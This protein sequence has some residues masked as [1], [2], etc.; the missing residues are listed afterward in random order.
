MSVYELPAKPSLE[1]LKK[2][3][4]ALLRQ[5]GASDAAASARF[6]AFS[7]TSA[8]PKLADALHVIAREHGFDTWPALKLHIEAASEDPVEALTAAVKANSASLVREVLARHPSLKSRINEPLPKYCDGAPAII[9]AV[10]HNN[11]EMIDALLDA[12]ANINE[13]SRWWAGGFGVLDSANP[14]LAP[15]LISRGATVDI[16]AAARLGM[17]DRVRELLHGNPELVHAR[18]GDGQLPLHFASGIEVAALLLDS[19]A[20]I[21]A[22]DVDHESTALQFMVAMQPYRHDVARFLLSRGAQADILAAS[23]L[24]DLA[25]VERI[26]N[27]DPDTVR[28]TVNERHFPKRDPRSGGSIYFYGFGV[29]KLPHMIAFQFGHTAVFDLLMQRSAPWLRLVQAAEI[30]DESLAQK[31]LQQHPT[32]VARLSANAARRLVGVAVRNN[33]RALELLLGYG[34]P[35]NAVLENNQTALHYAAWHGNLA[36]VQALL[37]HNAPVNVFETQYGGN[38]LFW[39]LHGSLHSWER[40]KGD[41]VGVA[42]TLLAAGASIPKPELPLEAAEDV[43]EVIQEH[44]A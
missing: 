15:Y 13:R 30:G 12:G 5:R 17:I 40:E 29:T 21:E 19:G 35:S 43:L 16:H 25:L 32:L 2:Q 38:P 7:I 34:W 23:A 31:I 1:H 10:N 14:E 41:Y 39:A 18:G 27:E 6:E 24:G 8:T 4:R 44:T 36:M 37:S 3:A 26:L 22:R 28:T 11:R 42:R 20:D 9:A 33:T